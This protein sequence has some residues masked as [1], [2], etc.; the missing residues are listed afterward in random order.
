MRSV[1]PFCC[2]VWGAGEAQHD[3]MC[4]QEGAKRLVVELTA[5]V[6]LEDENRESKLC[7]DEGMEREQRGQDVGLA[8][9]QECP[10]KV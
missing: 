10:H 2:D 4:S 1:R 6:G 3:P 9:Q 8:S 5:I 7:L